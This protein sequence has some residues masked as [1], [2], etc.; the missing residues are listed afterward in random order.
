LKDP[1]SRTEYLLMLEGIQL[2]EQSKIATE[3]ARAFGTEK[4]QTVPAEL[5]EEA[6]ELNML[7]E[8]TKLGGVDDDLRGQL[9][10]TR[11]GLTTRLNAMQDELRAAW[12]AWDGG[13]Q[14]AVAKMV[15]VLNRR[16]YLRNLLRDINDI[17]S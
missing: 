11:E 10:A 2:E 14:E 13:E 6:F 15:D 3:Q 8:E 17:L 9:V 12:K 16:S 7:L 4:K 1:I 5:L